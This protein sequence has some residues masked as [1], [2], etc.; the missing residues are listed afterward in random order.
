M[1]PKRGTKRKTEEDEEAHEPTRKSTR[2]SKPPARDVETAVP[3]KRTTTKAKAK[4]KAKAKG[5]GKAKKGSKKAEEIDTEEVEEIEPGTR[6]IMPHFKAKTAEPG[7]DE[8]ETQKAGST[9]GKAGSRKGKAGSSKGKAGSTKGKGKAGSKKAEAQT[10]STGKAHEQLQGQEVSGKQE[11]ASSGSHGGEVVEN[12]LI[13]FFYRPK[14]DVKESHAWQDVQRLYF[15]LAPSTSLTDPRAGHE[16]TKK[17]LFVMTSK[18]MP[19]STHAKSRHWAFVEA[20][21]ENM[22]DLHEILGMHTY[23]TK[24]RGERTLQSCRVCGEGVYQL[25]K[26]DECNATSLAYKLEVPH[27]PEEPQKAFGITSEAAFIVMIKNPEAPS[28]GFRGLG[29]S[30]KAHFPAELQKLFAGKRV[31]QRKFMPLD[32]PSFLDYQ[33]AEIIMMGESLNLKHFGDVGEHLEQEELEDEKRAEKELHGDLTDKPYAE[34][35]LSKEE[36][37]DKPLQG[38]WV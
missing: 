14:V 18:R 23:S 28:Q 34:L 20:V 12:G 30:Q 22:D 16:K 1:A 5:K 4:A 7:K 24:T 36:F 31:A 26:H 35:G 29:A 9:K 25:L 2:V 21:S 10:A 15:L 37:S 32:P 33:H 8:K 11:K 17:R 38:Q 6:R 27:T 19:T 3:A 13:Y